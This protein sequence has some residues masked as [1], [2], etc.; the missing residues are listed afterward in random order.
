[1]R[2]LMI[3]PKS[4]PMLQRCP[5]DRSWVGLRRHRPGARGGIHWSSIPRRLQPRLPHGLH[6][7]ICQ[8]TVT[9]VCKYPLVRSWPTRSLALCSPFIWSEA[10]PGT[11][12]FSRRTLLGH[13]YM[14]V[15]GRPLPKMAIAGPLVG[16]W[17]GGLPTLF[18]R[19]TTVCR[20]FKHRADVTRTMNEYQRDR[21]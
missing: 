13:A 14:R 7:I 9:A 5:N 8:F 17:V 10:L 21:T 12:V 19:G 4:A 3:R 15:S 6:R 2:H 16:G 11:R 18:E 20:F 1:M